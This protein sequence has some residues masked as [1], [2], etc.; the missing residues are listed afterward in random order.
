MKSKKVTLFIVSAGTFFFFSCASISNVQ[1]DENQTL[2][3]DSEVFLESSDSTENPSFLTAE[4]ITNDEQYL[5]SAILEEDVTETV[6]EESIP[7]EPVLSPEE[8]FLDS[9]NDISFELVSSP[10]EISKGKVFKEPFV[11]KVINQLNEPVCDFPVLVKYPVKREVSVL[12][13]EETVIKSGADGLVSILPEVKGFAANTK[14][15][16]SPAI[17]ED[18]N[19]DI[20]E[21]VAALEKEVSAPLK[22]KSDVVRKGAVLFIWDFNELNKPTGNSYDILSEFRSNGVYNVGNAPV[23]ETSDIGKN[24]TTLYK[25]NYEIIGTDFG[26]LIGGTIKFVQP[27]TKVDDGYEAQLIADIYAIDMSSGK[28]IFATTVENTSVGANWN[29]CVSA[30]KSELAKKIVNELFYGL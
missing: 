1:T 2:T 26:Y 11:V 18:L 22:I 27:V 7:E 8:I 3:Q 9:L 10:A 15:T 19:Q 12:V 24:K 4:N 23:N 28:E 13:F 6:A 30:S 29:K 20:V 21:K 14:V 17:P 5:D 25:Q 16:F